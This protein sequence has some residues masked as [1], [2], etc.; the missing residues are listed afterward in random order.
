MRLLIL[1]SLFAVMYNNA[2]A[3][4]GYYINDGQPPEPTNDAGEPDIRMAAEAVD[5]ILHPDGVNVDG[6]FEFVNDSDE[7]R[8]V[9]MFFPLNVG[10]L[11]LKSEARDKLDKGEIFG[12]GLEG[13]DVT[14]RFGI[15]IDGESVPYDVTGIYY[16]NDGSTEELTGSAVWTTNFAPGEKKMVEC[17]YYCNYGTQ[18]MVFG[19]REFYYVLYTGAPWKGP[20]GEGRITIR[21]G[22]DFD[23]AQPILPR[24]MDMPPLSVYEDRLE[25]TFT[26]FEPSA[27]N[28]EKGVKHG[29]WNGSAI[30]IVVPRGA[31]SD[32]RVVNGVARKK[33]VYIYRDHPDD[34]EDNKNSQIGEISPNG[35]ITLLERRGS[36]YRIFYPIT[37]ENGWIRWV[38]NEEETNEQVFNIVE[39]KVY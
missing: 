18:G 25:W 17:I 16:E 1:I 29:I 5:I 27:P 36:W 32:D 8:E 38:K 12:L 11:E 2:L 31:V 15:E 13:S 26:D 9:G 24:T 19:C 39:M 14:A 33:R 3:D 34:I 6:A 4:V 20:I 30:E 23:W 10:T 21:P 35:E 7:S 22:D 37:G 28:I